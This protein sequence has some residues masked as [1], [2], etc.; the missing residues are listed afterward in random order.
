MIEQEY[1]FDLMEYMEV[2]YDCN[3]ICRSSIFP[4]AK[5]AAL[6]S[7]QATCALAVKQELDT[8][9][10]IV[11]GWFM[12]GFIVTL[13]AWCCQYFLWCKYQS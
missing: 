2:K 6:G 11:I 4:F 7:P 5:P 10:P 13:L 3:G 12:A 1:A 8:T 9:G